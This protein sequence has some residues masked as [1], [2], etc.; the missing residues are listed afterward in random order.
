MATADEPRHTWVRLLVPWLVLALLATSARTE[1][2]AA[3]G[4]GVPPLPGTAGR[5]LRHSFALPRLHD[6]PLGGPARQLADLQVGRRAAQLGIDAAS[7]QA[8]WHQADGALNAARARLAL[9]APEAP[10][11]FS[12]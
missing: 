8:A 4:L 3:A 1:P 2:P 12:G 5:D 7:A 10:H 9:P 11:I 6:D